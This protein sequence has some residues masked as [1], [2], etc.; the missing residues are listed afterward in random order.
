MVFLHSTPIFNTIVNGLTSAHFIHPLD[1]SIRDKNLLT[2]NGI[3]KQF[4]QLNDIL[5]R[6]YISIQ[7]VYKYSLTCLC[8]MFF[9]INNINLSV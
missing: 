3:I 1:T 2:I 9:N 5:L 8:R 4:S 6:L 7:F